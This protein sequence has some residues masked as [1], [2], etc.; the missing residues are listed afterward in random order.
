MS[1]TSIPRPA[2]GRARRSVVAGVG[3]TAA[4]V[5]ASCGAPPSTSGSGAGRSA[6][7]A[8]GKVSAAD[9]PLDAL[10]KADGPVKVKLWF[11]GLV[12]PP[13]TVMTDLVKEF[14]ASQDKVQVTADNQGNAYA[15][16]LRKYE[17]AS[18]TPSQLPDMIY[19]EDTALGEMVDKGQ[20]L[21]AEACMLADD[22]DMTQITAS[23][24]GAYSVDGVLYPGYM[25]VSSPILYFNKA[26]FQKAG[27]DPSDAPT[28]L[29]ELE[30]T[31]KKLKAAGVSKKPLSFLTNQWF[32]S[33]WMAGVGQDMV[34]NNNGR[35][36]PATEATFDSEPGRT[37][38]EWL[39]RMN[40]EGLLNPFPVTDGSID[41]YLAL[42][43]EDSSMLI[44]TSTASGTI[45][46]ALGGEISA[47]DNGIDLD[48]AALSGL[49]IVPGS[50]QLP[51]IQSPGQ[52]YASG[53]AYYMLNTGSDAEQA[54][55]W[56][57][58]KFMLQ[59]E[60]AKKWFLNG[61][62]IPVIKEVVNDPDVQQF[63]KDEVDGVLLAPS[64]QQLGA[65][66]P[67]RVGPLIG[68]YPKFQAILQ[69]AMEQVL[70]SGADPD[71]ALADANA[72]ATQ[73]LKDYNN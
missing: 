22:Y 54:A 5:L 72:K 60:N 7:G 34:D 52:V 11:G 45:A 12:E 55:S 30:A 42:V 10:D 64:V 71:K 27:I 46:A 38:M 21:P 18:A 57:F 68:P 19:L 23:A 33:T 41:Q 65:A 26:H 73:L 29:D 35:T 49:N 56:E 43:T 13:S 31:A 50:A 58:M 67:D 40:K 44:E 15:E 28:T 32:F 9:C 20:V 24:R 69:G 63:Q 61:G 25:N 70:F 17:G 66:D 8:A 59:P 48:A 1:T 51:G 47:S 36:K 39:D 3:V 6:E 2:P 14:N 62:Y 4:L 37:I 53:G 16:V